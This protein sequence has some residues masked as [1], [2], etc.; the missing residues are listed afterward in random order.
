MKVDY[1]ILSFGE[2]RSFPDGYM[3]GISV[4]GITVYG[5]RGYLPG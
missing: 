4:K 1:S 3:K 5:I 2:V